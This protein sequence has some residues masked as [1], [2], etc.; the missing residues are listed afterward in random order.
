MGMQESTSWYVQVAEIF[1]AGGTQFSCAAVGNF[2]LYN[3]CPRTCWKFADVM[4]IISVCLYMCVCDHSPCFTMSNEIGLSV[5]VT[6]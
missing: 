5:I 6:S 1:S 4:Y 3:I 2:P